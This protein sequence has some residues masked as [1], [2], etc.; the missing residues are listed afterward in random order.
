MDES[1]PS[2]YTAVCD[3]LA[4]RGVIMSPGQLRERYQQ[5]AHTHITRSPSRWPDVEIGAVFDE[6]IAP[7]NRAGATIDTAALAWQWR[8]HS[9]R[10][11]I[12]YPE[13]VATLEALSKVARLCIISNTQRLFTMPELAHFDLPCYF[14]QIIISSD[15]CLCKPDPAIFE[16]G[17][18]RMN[19]APEN[20]IYVGDN[21]FDDVYGAGQ[22][23]MKTVWL[24]RPQQATFPDGYVRPTPDRTI[25]GAAFGRL[26]A[27]IT[28]LFP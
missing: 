16:A 26:A 17:C 4:A 13:T 15:L 23:G 28:E 19:V 20:A 21:I 24:K 18:E 5:I 2:L 9:T 3:W 27:I 7:Y 14:E 25:E 6:V 10:D 22:V 8:Q 12:I 11:L 1:A